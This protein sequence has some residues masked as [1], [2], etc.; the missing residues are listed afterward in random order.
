MLLGVVRAV[1][2]PARPNVDPQH[3]PAVKQFSTPRVVN[4]DPYR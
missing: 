3:T 4:E 2:S 1:D